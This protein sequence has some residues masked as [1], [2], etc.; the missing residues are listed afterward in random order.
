M[1][2]RP[3]QDSP[4]SI[5]N[6]QEELNRVFERFWHAGV[7]A[8]PFDGQKW[9][10]FIDLYDRGEHYALYAE[11]PG[12][13]AGSVEVT[14]LGGTLTIRGQKTKPACS[15]G[16]E[17][18]L[19]GERRFGTFCRTI[20]LPGDVDPDKLSATCRDGVLEI[21]IPKSASSRPKTVKVKVNGE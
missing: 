11:V 18:M 1:A 6:L 19:R 2:F 15:C 12:V 8:G 14:Q 13:D 5:G 17:R 4:V 9:A 3:F 10:P 20:E 16:E 21:T 7:S